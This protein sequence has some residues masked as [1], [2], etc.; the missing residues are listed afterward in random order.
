MNSIEKY[1]SKRKEAYK[2]LELRDS[3]GFI[4]QKTSGDISYMVNIKLDEKLGF[5][6]FEAHPGIGSKHPA[7]MPMLVKY[8][9]HAKLE[10]GTL[11]V[12][13]LFKEVYYRCEAYFADGEIG[14]NTLKVLENYAEKAFKDHLGA[15]RCISNGKL[16]EDADEIK[17]GEAQTAPD[18]TENYDKSIEAIPQYLAFSVIFNSVAE[19]VN[20]LS[21]QVYLAELL[22]EDVGR[23]KLTF[24]A[25]KD[26]TVIRVKAIPGFEEEYVSKEYAYVTSRF[27]NDKSDEKK[28]GSFFVDT[29][30]GACCF[31]DLVIADT[32]VTLDALNRTQTIILGMME[33]YLDDF[34]LASMGIM[35]ERP[36]LPTFFD[37]GLR[38]FGKRMLDDIDKQIE[39]LDFRLGKTNIEDKTEAI[40]AENSGSG[41][42]TPDD[43]FPDFDS[44]PDEDEKD[45]KDEE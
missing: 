28:L 36:R 4:Y 26:Q 40:L 24:C 19:N 1:L 20:V 11:R 45:E 31:V 22:D 25:N 44:F 23:I 29:N 3:Q 10:V 38:N 34:R 6:I 7:L 9:Q 16:I 30:G 18:N 17:C 21:P 42:E 39:D 35:S 32:P 8:C 5:M 33:E 14:E 27:C 12:G 15:I 2:K 13:R 43:A 41:D 37:T